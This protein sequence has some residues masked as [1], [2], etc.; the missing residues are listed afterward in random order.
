MVNICV[1]YKNSRPYI[2]FCI[3]WWLEEIH[4]IVGMREDLKVVSGWLVL[5]VV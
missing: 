3:G 5:E 1:V 2:Y 4:F